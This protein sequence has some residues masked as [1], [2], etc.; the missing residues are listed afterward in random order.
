M[1]RTHED[2][3]CHL[4]SHM[5]PVADAGTKAATKAATS[6]DP[7]TEVVTPAALHAAAKSSRR[8]IWPWVV[9][10]VAA[11]LVLALVGVYLAGVVAFGGLLSLDSVSPYFLPGTTIDGQDVSLERVSDVAAEKSASLDGL[12]VSVSGDGLDLVVDALD[13]GLEVD[14]T[15]W[16]EEALAQQD[17]WSWPLAYLGLLEQELTATTTVS[18]DEDAVLDIVQAAVDALDVVEVT[19]IESITFDAEQGLYVTVEGASTVQVDVE[20]VADAIVAALLAQEG[21][22]ELGDEYLIVD[23][24]VEAF[25]ELANSYV[26]AEVTLLLADTEVYVVTSEQIAGWL[27]LN[28]DFTVTLDEDAIVTWARGDL[29]D[30]LDTVATERTYTRPDGKVCTVNDGD[31]R[32]GSSTYGWII[33]GAS[34][35]ADIAELIYA[36]EPAELDITVKQEAAQASVDGG[37]DWGDRY[38]DI[39]LTEQHAY[40]Y[41]NGELIWEA[42]IVSGQPSTGYETPSGVWTVQNMA[43]GNITLRGPYDE[44]TG[45]Y[46]WESVV[47]FWIAFVGSSVGLHNAS[48]RSEFGGDI[49]TWYGSHG[50]VNLSYEDAE[51][52]YALVEVGDVVVVH[53]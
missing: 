40:F 14:G 21:E 23:E 32:L 17:P 48:W 20:A 53:E 2:E 47:N 15:S 36:G 52:L 34:T 25:L 42:D 13:A 6:A 3:G 29:S 8:R 1:T 5:K 51:A 37:Q 7:V 9:G 50:C 12:Q 35:A 11:V 28:E 43:S 49:Y 22:V 24:E 39:D 27:T 41:D 4:P 38:I 16:A 33:D 44:D 46:E 45:T 18:V 30:E 31:A 10:G 26:S 19:G